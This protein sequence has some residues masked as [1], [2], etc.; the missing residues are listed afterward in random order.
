MSHTHNHRL[1]G[2]GKKSSFL[3]VDAVE[4]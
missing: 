4:W 2:Y 1:H 3:V